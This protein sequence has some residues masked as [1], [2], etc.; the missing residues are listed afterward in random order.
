MNNNTNSAVTSDENVTQIDKYNLAEF[1][2]NY[3]AASDD[4]SKSPYRNSVNKKII[5]DYVWKEAGVK[6]G[7]GYSGNL[8]LIIPFRDIELSGRGDITRFEFIFDAPPKSVK[9]NK[10][11]NRGSSD[12]VADV[13]VVGVKSIYDA[14]EIIVFEGTAKALAVYQALSLNES[15]T[16]AMFVIARGATGVAKVADYLVSINQGNKVIIG[17]DNDELK[18]PK[19]PINSQV[20]KAIERHSLKYV[21]PPRS[22]KDFDEVL[23]ANPSGDV[24][25]DLFNKPKKLLQKDSLVIESKTEKQVIELAGV[26][27]K[28][29]VLGLAGD[30]LFA[31]KEENRK[32]KLLSDSFFGSLRIESKGAMPAI[33]IAG[34]WQLIPEKRD[35]ILIIKAMYDS[36]SEPYSYKKLSSMLDNVSLELEK[37]GAVKAHTI[38]FKNGAYNLVTGEFSIHS[39]DNFLRNT[40]QAVWSEPEDGE[41]LKDVAPAFDKWLGFVSNGQLLK[42]HSILAVMYAVLFNRYDWQL[43]VEITGKGGTGKSTFTNLLI[44]LVGDSNYTTSSINDLETPDSRAPLVGK[45]LVILPD[46]TEYAG[47]GKGLIAITG[48]DSVTINEKYLPRYSTVLPVVVVAINNNPMRFTDGAGGVERRRVNISMDR[49]VNVNDRVD[50]LSV[51]IAKELPAIVRHILKTFPK[52]EDAKSV[53]HNQMKSPEAIRLKQESSIMVDFCQHFKEVSVKDGLFIGGAGVSLKPN[54]YLF[55]AYLKFCEY[56]GAKSPVSLKRFKKAMETSLDNYDISFVSKRITAGV[57]TNLQ[58]IETKDIEW[59]SNN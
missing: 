25:M 18:D 8:G 31:K 22:F 2:F 24:I 50:S 16:K 17:C 44:S 36:I 9:S 58:F 6:H 49:A 51:K 15:H 42:Q 35:Q 20:M 10:F 39:P 11:P 40:N 28:S 13:L 45:S 57:K 38:G 27:L 29:A 37:L 19:S 46:Q 26:K 5:L 47:A 34:A 32:A 41:L 21:I 33:Y 4:L 23:V 7:T 3:K 52:P 43:F 54:K 12:S 53:L 14:K 1:N 55:H 56:N 48:G 59:L 30:E